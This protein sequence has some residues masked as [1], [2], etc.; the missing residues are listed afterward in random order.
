MAL[1]LCRLSEFA[2]ASLRVS[3]TL[4]ITILFSS[5]TILLSMNRNYNSTT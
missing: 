3:K 4:P 1:P 5:T 2:I